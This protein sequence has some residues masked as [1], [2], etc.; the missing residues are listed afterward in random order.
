MKSKLTPNQKIKILRQ[1]NLICIYC[2]DPANEVDHIFPYSYSLNDREENLVASCSICNRIA[3]D[4]VFDGLI[5][6]QTYILEER[7][8][9]RWIEAINIY[10]SLCQ[11]AGLPLPPIRQ[12]EEKLEEKPKEKPKQRKNL[13]G[14]SIMKKP[15]LP[16]SWKSREK[17]AVKPK[18]DICKTDLQRQMGLTASAL[19][20][21]NVYSYR[22]LFLAKYQQE[23]TW[24]NVAKQY[25]LHPNMVRLI[26]YGH[27]PGNKIRKKLNLPLKSEIESMDG[28]IPEGS[29]ALGAIACRKC[30]QSFISNHPRRRK[31]FICSPYRS[32]KK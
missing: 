8:K 32:R 20:Y 3:G 16:L 29:L 19:N 26:A 31:C 10:Q 2:G 18:Q 12:T 28:N 6:K 9:R 4:K 11:A 13:D 17:K 14:S 15:L 24:R 7:K 21:S 30:G 23:G 5:E 22:L 25:G 27:R 1:A